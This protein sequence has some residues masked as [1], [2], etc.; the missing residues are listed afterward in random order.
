M[1]IGIAILV[2]L[3]C[4]L[5][6]AWVRYK[7]KAMKHLAQY[8][9]IHDMKVE[10]A[11]TKNNLHILR[12]RV[13]EETSKHDGAMAEM[14]KLYSQKKALVEEATLD[15][16]VIDAGLFHTEYNFVDSEKYKDALQENRGKQKELIRA[17]NAAVCNKEWVVDGSAAIGAQM[18]KEML[19]LMQRA[20]NG[21]C[22]NFIARVTYRNGEAMKKKIKKAFQDI[23][24]L[25]AEKQCAITQKLLDLKLAE[26]ELVYGF[27]DRKEKERQEQREIQEE[28]REEAKAQKE[29]EKARQAAEKEESRI[30]AALEKA[31]EEIAGQTD[32]QRLEFEKKIALLEAQLANA[33]EAKARAISQAQLT[34]SG[35]VYVISNI[36]S[37]GEDVY[38]VG[39]TRR[40][41][42]MD[43]V[44]ELG[45]AS[46]PFNFDVHALAYSENAPELEKSMHDALALYRVNRINERRE[47]FRVPLAT[48]AQEM[49]KHDA[50]IRFTMAAEAQEYRESLRLVGK[51]QRFGGAQS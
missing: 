20:F 4:G 42:P 29:M 3:I 24:A 32:A 9:S 23:N 19:T 7:L 40:L 47:F 27:N 1:G 14:D 6:I 50:D 10:E 12:K 8:E 49:K 35:H 41:E 45:D 46:V 2:V 33:S 36:G 51:H 34:K 16:D 11:R 44:K 28:M 31:R 39:L 25:G 13:E 38:K 5:T 43:R 37:F 21:E 22:D 30:A 15:A 18:I 26:L 48:I 17:K